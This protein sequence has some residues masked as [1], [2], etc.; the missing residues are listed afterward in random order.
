MPASAVAALAGALISD[1]AKGI[2]G[3]IFGVRGGEVFVFN[4]PRPVRSIHHQ[5][6][7]PMGKLARML[8]KFQ[9]AFAPV[10]ELGR[11]F[12]WDPVEE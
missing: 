9:S 10:S 1:D 7:W 5:G 3:Q 8:P 11:T 2:S 4:Q 12:M 6:G